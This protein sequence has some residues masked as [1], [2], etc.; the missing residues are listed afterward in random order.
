M[1]LGSKGRKR[2]RWRGEK[3]AGGFVI[4]AFLVAESLLQAPFRRRQ[5]EGSLCLHCWSLRHSSHHSFFGENLKNM[6]GDGGGNTVDIILEF[7]DEGLMLVSVL[8]PAVSENWR[9]AD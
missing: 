1:G 5:A 6:M 4:A 9:R 2:S 7:P 3:R 8:Y